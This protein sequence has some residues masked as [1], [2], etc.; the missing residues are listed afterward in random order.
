MGLAYSRKIFK[1]I[2]LVGYGY[3]GKNLA[4]NFNTQMCA[5]CDADETKLDAAKK[6]YPHIKLYSN[7]LEAIN[8]SDVTAVAIATKAESH[9]ELAKICIQEGKDLWIEKPV[10]ENL[11]QVRSLEKLAREHEK[12]VFIDHTFCYTP[13]VQKMKQIDIGK[14]L[15]YDSTRISL[16]LFQPDVD[17]VLDLAIHDVSI[18]NYLYPDLV[19]ETK[20][21]TRNSHVN[22]QANQAIINL[23]FTNGF[24]ANINVNWV[25]PVKKRQI[26]LTGDKSSIIFDDLDNDKIKIYEIGSIDKDYNAN[27]LGDMYAPKL[28]TTEALRAGVDHFIEC[29]QTRNRPITDI[30]NSLKIM[31]W[32]L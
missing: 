21:I 1:M 28:N 32:I 2:L 4:R 31:E 23:K 15:Y 26:I 13:A 19:L 10:C 5:I 20:T 18:L 27:K 14:P 9:F 16:G 12:I 22:D 30:T 8:D 3:W 6:L 29:C 7:F 24:T 11:E 25:S 17:V